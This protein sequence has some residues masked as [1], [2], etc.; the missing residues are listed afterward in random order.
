V[1]TCCTLLLAPCRDIHITY[2][3]MSNRKL[4]KYIKPDVVSLHAIGGCK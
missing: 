2:K 4:S 1:L 3:A